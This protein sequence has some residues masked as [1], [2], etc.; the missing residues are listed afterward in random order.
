MSRFCGNNAD[1]FIQGTAVATDFPMTMMVWVY[2]ETLPT[3][4]GDEYGLIGV[5]RSTGGSDRSYIRIDDSSSQN[6]PQ[7]VIGNTA[8]SFSLVTHTNS[9]SANTWHFICGVANSGSD[10][11]IW[12]DSTEVNSSV[13]SRTVS[14]LNS[15]S[16]GAYQFASSVND[17]AEAWIEW[18]T[19][20][21]VALSDREVQALAAGAWPPSI[22]PESI[23]GCWPLM[24]KANS[25]SAQ[26][27]FGILDIGSVS[28]PAAWST[29]SAPVAVPRSKLVQKFVS[30]PPPSGDI[31]PL[32]YHHRH[33]NMAG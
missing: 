13:T 28:D 8:G 3:A 26:D 7:M 2:V 4:H 29:F 16:I 15:T 27:L 18:G 9:I 31:A 20:W 19:I 24:E 23:V 6:R 25:D 22:R 1:Y 33:H 17:I 32:H 12:L 10:L 30:G 5:T 21:D 11:S 14:G